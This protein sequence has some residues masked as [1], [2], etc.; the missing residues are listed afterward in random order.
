QINKL[1]STWKTP[2]NTLIIDIDKCT[3]CRVCELICSMTNYGEVNPEKAY[4][5][6]M[7]N[8]EMDINIAALDT[9]CTLCNECVEWCLPG[10]LEFI[11]LEEAVAIFKGA[12][13][14]RIPTPM[15]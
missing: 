9:S 12:H 5:K 13:V 14:G 11:D 6:V 7:K 15:V 8:K 1:Q 3:G 10:A 4:I 2:F